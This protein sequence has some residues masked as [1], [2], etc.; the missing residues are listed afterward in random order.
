MIPHGTKPTRSYSRRNF[1]M[2]FQPSS[3]AGRI[4][5]IAFAAAAALSLAPGPAF[6]QPKSDAQAYPIRPVRIILP[7][8]AGSAM[9]VVTRRISQRL[10]EVWGQQ[11]V[12]D[13]RAGA[14]GIIGH[15]IASKGR[16][17]ATTSSSPRHP[18]SSSAPSS[19]K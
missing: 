11:V 10:T 18:A 12:V 3:T 17:T 15:E 16:P 9:D 1:V 6:A 4:A 8:T 13:N 5:S 2:H 7:N 19:R 14:S